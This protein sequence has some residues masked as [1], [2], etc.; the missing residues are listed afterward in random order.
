MFT[1]ERSAGT[2]D[3]RRLLHTVLYIGECIYARGIIAE[4]AL[5]LNNDKD[6]GSTIDIL[7]GGDV[8]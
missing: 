6:T 5:V 4:R 3:Y 7:T 1:G 8:I 2:S